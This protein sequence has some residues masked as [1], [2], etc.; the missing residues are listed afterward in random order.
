M[1]RL[2]AR[3]VPQ[4]NLRIH[5][6]AGRGGAGRGGAGTGP[7][8]FPGP[9]APASTPPPQPLRRREVAQGCTNPKL[10]GGQPSLANHDPKT[11]EAGCLAAWQRANEI[12]ASGL[13]VGEG[14]G[15]WEGRGEAGGAKA[16]EG[17]AAALRLPSG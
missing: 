4:I 9:A 10:T 13:V 1:R 3:L 6:G 2:A 7:N 11:R 12:C 14:N 8:G 15:W 16:L 17:R 5:G